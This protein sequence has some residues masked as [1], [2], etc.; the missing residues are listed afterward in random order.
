MAALVRRAPAFCV[1]AWGTGMNYRFGDFELDENARS[2][3][4]RGAIEDVQPRVLELLCYL[5]RHAGRV[6]PKDEL[7]DELWPGVIVTESS[8]QRAASLARKTLADG[9]LGHA[10]QNFPKRGYRF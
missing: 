1:C 4:L 9:G 10:I 2:L 3:T 5:V 6:V 7:L 8:L